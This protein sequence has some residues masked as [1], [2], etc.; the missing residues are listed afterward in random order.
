MFH[1]KHRPRI[2]SGV[3]IPVTPEMTTAARGGF[4]GSTC[5]T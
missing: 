4:E 1:V 3:R 5:F 2:A